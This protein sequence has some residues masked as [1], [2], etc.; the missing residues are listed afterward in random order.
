MLRHTVD[1]VIFYVVIDN[2]S[3]RSKPYIITFIS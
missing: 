2:L 3:A 1:K